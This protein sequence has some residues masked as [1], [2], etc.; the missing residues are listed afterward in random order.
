MHQQGALV[1]V[2]GR[3]LAAGSMD[4]IGWVHFID[5]RGIAG[6]LRGGGRSKRHSACF[7]V[8]VDGKHDLNWNGV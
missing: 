5:M 6:A 1:I 8:P 4:T 7:M 3:V 2:V